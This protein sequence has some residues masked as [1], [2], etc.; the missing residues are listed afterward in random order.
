MDNMTTV[1]SQRGCH[2]VRLDAPETVLGAQQ[3]LERPSVG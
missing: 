3:G 2:R 1:T